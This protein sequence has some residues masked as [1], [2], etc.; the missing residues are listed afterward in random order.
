MPK[1]GARNRTYASIQDHNCH[2]WLDCFT[3]LD[4]LFEQLRFLFM[5]PRRVYNDDF[6]AF[7]FE[8]SHSLSCDRD[9]VRFRIRAKVS[10][11]GLGRRLS[12]LIESTSTEGI[13]AHN[14]RSEASLLVMYR[15]F[16]TRCSLAVPL[17]IVEC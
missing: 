1:Q 11:F 15:K 13:S 16:G 4:H 2:I 7:L 9:G 5:S 6:K 3:D 8:L 14:S 17:I 10:Y 12:C